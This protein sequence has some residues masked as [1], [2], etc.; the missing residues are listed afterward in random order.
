VFGGG[1]VA[2]GVGP[3]ALGWAGNHYRI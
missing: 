1:M 2:Q 3:V